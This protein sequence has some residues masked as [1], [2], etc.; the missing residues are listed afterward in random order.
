MKRMY[1]SYWKATYTNLCKNCTLA[2]SRPST[3]ASSRDAGN[4]RNRHSGVCV[5]LERAIRQQ[6]RWVLASTSHPSL[7]FWIVIDRFG[8]A[9]LVTFLQPNDRYPKQSD[10]RR[11]G[12]LSLDRHFHLPI[13]L[14][15]FCYLAYHRQND[16]PNCKLQQETF[17][18]WACS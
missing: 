17:W 16:K 15:F 11:L 12:R 14:F 13:L 5:E 10:G 8:L 6:V 1:L 18:T 7:Y 9:N 3:T 2:S 4:N